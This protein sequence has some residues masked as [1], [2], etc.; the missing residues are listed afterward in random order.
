MSSS[1]EEQKLLELIKDLERFSREV[2]FPSGLNIFEAAGMHRQEIRHSNFLAFLLRPQETHG[3]GAESWQRVK[4]KP[5]RVLRR[6]CGHSGRR[7]LPPRL[8]RMRNQ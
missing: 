4:E 1:E 5:Q 6:N 3:L 8:P 7:P 2:R